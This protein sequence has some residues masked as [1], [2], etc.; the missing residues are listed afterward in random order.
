MSGATTTTFASA[1][2]TYMNGMAE[3]LNDQGAT[4]QQLIPATPSPGGDSFDWPVHYGGNSSTVA[5]SEGDALAAAGNESYATATVAYSTG[6]LRTVYQVTGHARD[7]VRNGYFN[8]VD[9]EGMSALMAHVAAREALLISTLEGAI[10]SA[11]SYAG[12]LRATYN[13]A[14]YEAAIGGS[15]AM[16]NMDLM[17]ETLQAS[18]IGADLSG[19]VI[20]A[21]TSTI[22]EYNDVA[23][24]A[25]A[26]NPI[27]QWTDGKTMD[28]GKFRF[29]AAYNG[30]P[31]VRV[32]G[33]TA[34]GLLFVN[35]SNLVRVVQ[36][37]I[38]VEPM[39]KTDDSDLFSIT[40]SEII[41]CLN[42]RHAGKLTT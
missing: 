6:Y 28:G 17:Y 8:A 9:K 15:L 30:C 33:L 21:P 42:P 12:L 1:I 34:G 26:G 40:S 2:A 3:T 16:A 22:G 29:N 38:I 13:L 11:G 19:H 20:L 25:G 24:G 4:L 5:Y 39:A 27:I 10:D 36:R 32:E 18:P 41:V 23:A 14:S 7:A 31:I 37:P 35:P